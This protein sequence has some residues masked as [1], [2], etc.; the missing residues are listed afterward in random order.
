MI[1]N[2]E[3]PRWPAHSDVMR[4]LLGLAPKQKLPPEGMPPRD[5]QGWTVWVEPLA[6]KTSRW[7]RSTHRVMARCRCGKVISAGRTGQHRCGTNINQEG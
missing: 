3:Y 4:Q 7:R 5:I 6:P 2:P 1:R